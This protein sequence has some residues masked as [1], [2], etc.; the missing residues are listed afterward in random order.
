MLELKTEQNEEE[1][2]PETKLWRAVI[3]RAF[4]DVIYPG[5]ERSLIMFKY[6]AHLWFVDDK[7]NFKLICNLAGMSDEMVRNKYLEMVD[8]EQI[9]FTQDQIGYINW[10]KK[11]NARRDI[12]D[13]T[14]DFL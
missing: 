9:Y 1:L 8:N 13:E 11:Y 2:S 10:R 6:Q 7:E 3:Q 12:D 5:M 14:G 4:E